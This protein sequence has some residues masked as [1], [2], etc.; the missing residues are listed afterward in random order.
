M[1]H[2]ITWNAVSEEGYPT[3]DGS[4]LVRFDDGDTPEIMEYDTYLDEYQW[5]S[6]ATAKHTWKVTSWVSIY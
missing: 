3:E 1:I 6:L 2:A 4:Y 5:E